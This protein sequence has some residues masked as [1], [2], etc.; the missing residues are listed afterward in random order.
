MNNKR[1]NFSELLP[2]IE[3]SLSQGESITFSPS[4]QSMLPLLKQ[5]RDKVVLGPVKGEIRKYDIVFFKRNDGAFVLHRVVKT[6]EQLTVSGD[7]RIYED[8]VA[9]SQIIGVVTS[10]ERKGKKYVGKEMISGPY[11]AFVFFRRLLRKVINRIRSI[12]RN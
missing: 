8:I 3:D 1:T 6:G 7:N 5:G 2:L 12:G 11:L 9:P 4:G 10:F